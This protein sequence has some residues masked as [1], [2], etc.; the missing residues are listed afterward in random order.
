MAV[1]WR[2]TLGGV[3][4]ALTI[5]GASA[6]ADE[7][8]TNP[9]GEWRVARGVATVRV[10]DCNGQY[11]GVIA[12]EQ[13]PGTDTKNPDPALRGRPTLGM[14]ILLQMTPSR[15]NEWSGS[16]YNAEDGRIYA[17]SISL[18]GPDTLQVKGCVLGIL[19]GGENWTR[20]A[21]APESAGGASSQSAPAKPGAR[22]PSQA[23]AQVSPQAQ[24]AD[25][26]CSGLVGL[27]RSPH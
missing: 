19:C 6:R 27:P 7:P 1:T 3:C 25:D 17:G 13:T 16:I 12:S 5:A 9:I 21:A 2:A 18:V 22:D 14:P 24:S 10:V 8:P 23:R 11:W 4:A 26:I 20:V 15:A